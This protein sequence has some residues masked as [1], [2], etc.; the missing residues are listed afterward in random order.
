MNTRTLTSTPPPH[1]PPH[2]VRDLDLWV[3]LAAAGKDA[4]ARA[5][6][7]HQQLPPIFWAKSLGYLE[8]CWVPRRAED[9]RRVLQDPETF[10]SDGVLAFSALMGESWRLIPIEIDPP[11]HTQFRVLLNPL[12]SPKKVAQMDADIRRHASDLISGFAA[13]GRCDFNAEF[14][15]RFPTLTFLR[16]MGW[17][18]N[19]APKFALWTRTLVKSSDPILAGAACREIAT[20]FRLR[21]AERRSNPSDDF[22]NHVLSYEVDG[23]KLTDEE[24][25]GI[26]VL[27]FLAGLDTVTSAL[28]FQFLHLARHPDHQAQLRE[29]PELIP[30][31]V[32]ELLRA[33]SIVNM[34]RLVTRDVCIGEA[35]MRKG[36]YV[37]ISPELANLDP[38]EFDRP[39]EVDFKRVEKG[40]MTFSSGPHRCLGSHLARRELVIAMQ[41]WIARVPPFHVIDD[42]LIELRAAAVFGLDNLTLEW[43]GAVPD[44]P[45]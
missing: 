44:L 18:V 30:A 28:A 26:C 41:E 35:P 14:A 32:E 12:F 16:L 8:G 34:R 6:N 23:R 39:T 19:E 17:P 31:A 3:D 40:N 45:A 15:N 11:L 1:V 4:F 27:V 5:A 7:Y 36:D 25:L 22:T 21:I 10:S 43:A 42:H 33:Y 37:M 38:E 13:A 24:V 29:N 9:L 2:L 20:Y